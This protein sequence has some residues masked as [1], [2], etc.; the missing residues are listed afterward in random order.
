MAL[1]AYQMQANTMQLLGVG[2]MRS[3]I[4]DNNKKLLYLLLTTIEK[5]EE[6]LI[7][8]TEMQSEEMLSYSAD[9]VDGVGKAIENAPKTLNLKEV[10]K[11][12]SVG[13]R[14][15]TASLAEE[16]EVNV[17]EIIR[18]FSLMKNDV[19]R[20]IKVFESM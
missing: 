14:N 1:A 8:E 9:M 3:S 7:F 10:L 5:I 6:N 17:K 20:Y 11:V 12:A 18:Q 16:E 2:S 4:I 19:K 15:F 13:H